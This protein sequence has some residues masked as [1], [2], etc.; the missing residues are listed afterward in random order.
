MQEYIGVDREEDNWR[1]RCNMICFTVWACRVHLPTSL[2]KVMLLS[3]VAYGE[4]ICFRVYLYNHMCAC[5]NKSRGSGMHWV[6]GGFKP[7]KG[8]YP[9][10]NV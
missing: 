9:P 1:R 10:C 7:T 2:V 4:K 6:G 8:Q 3:C 5:I